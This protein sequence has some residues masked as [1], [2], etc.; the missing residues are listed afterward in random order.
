MCAQ[1]IG[2]KCGVLIVD[3]GVRA[4]VEELIIGFFGCLGDLYLLT[5][6]KRVLVWSPQPPPHH[7]QLQHSH[8]PVLSN[9]TTHEEVEEE[10]R[11]TES[12]SVSGAL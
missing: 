7:S 3:V 2:F 11:M 4:H 9:T 10:E 12:P 8:P 1:T 6:H 5:H